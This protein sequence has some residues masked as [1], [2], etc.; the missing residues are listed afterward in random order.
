[1][2]YTEVKDLS[3]TELN[4]K[5]KALQADLFQAKMKNGLGQL[6]NPL[7]IR[8]VRRELAR[9]QTALTAKQK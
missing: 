6:A 9:V 2:K 4:K 5:R 3:A 1:M 7:E 8:K